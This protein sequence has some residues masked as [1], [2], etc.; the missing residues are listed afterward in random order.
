MSNWLHTSVRLAYVG[1]KANLKVPPNQG[2]RSK[3][4]FEKY[5]LRLEMILRQNNNPFFLI[6]PK[7]T[8]K[9]RYKPGKPSIL[10]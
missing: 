7:G 2:F 9:G 3:N 10:R 4:Y 6:E 8:L 5:G 1:T